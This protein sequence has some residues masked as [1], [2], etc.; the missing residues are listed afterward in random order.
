M[1]TEETQRL[2]DLALRGELGL[3]WVAYAG[4]GVVALVGAYFGAYFKQRGE[5]Y[6]T[7]QDLKEI[8]SIAEEIRAKVSNESWQNQRFW[9]EKKAIYVDLIKG[10]SKIADGLWEHLLH[11][12]DQRTYERVENPVRQASTKALHE[13]LGRYLQFTGVAFVFLNEQAHH[14]M[15]YFSDESKRLHDQLGN[16]HDA[17]KY[18]SKLKEV[19][20]ETYSQMVKAAKA[21]LAAELR[22]P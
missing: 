15:R 17:Y 10:L 21:D 4:V 16:D 12:F 19:V 22:K 2:V 8:T 3:S 11:G 18:F 14:A 5:N 20:D 1:T 6:A 9:E 13:S 7:K